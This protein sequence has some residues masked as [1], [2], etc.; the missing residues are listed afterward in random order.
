MIH[1]AFLPLLALFALPTFVAST[2][3]ASPPNFVFILADD[4]GWNALSIPADPGEPASGSPYFQTP[5]LA[6]LAVNGMRF[7]QA[8]SPAPTCSPSRHSIQFGRSPASLRIWGA[9]GIRNWNAIDGESLANVLKKARPEYVCAHFGKWHI[10]RSPEALGYEINDGA[11]GNSAGNSKN[12]KDPKKIFDLSRKSNEFMEKQVQAGRPFYLQVSHYAN[13]LKYQGLRETI[14][15]YETKYAGK[16]TEHH[17]DPLWAAMNENLDTG[18]GMVLDKIDELGIAKNTYVFYTADNGYESKRDFKKTVSERGYYKAFP[19]RSHKYHVSEG[20]IRVPFIVRGPGI[21][22]N[23]HSSFPVVGT[24]VFPTVMDLIESSDKVPSR[25]EGASLMKHLKSGGKE[26]I[27]RKDPFL[28]FKF[29]KP[30]PPHDIAIV[31]GDHKLIKD[32]DTGESFLFNLKK[33]VGESKNIIKENPELGKQ[34]YGNM[35]EYFARFSWDESKIKTR[36]GPSKAKKGPKV[37]PG[38][39]NVTKPRKKRGSSKKKPNV[40]IIFIDDMGY[41]DIGPFGSDHPTPHLDRMA[42]EGMKLTDFYVSSAACTPSR[43]ALLTGCYADRIGMGKSVVFPADKRGLNPKEITIAEILKNAGYAT[44]CFGKWHLGDQPQFMP[45]AQGFDKYE[46]IPYSN[47]MWVKGNPKRKYPPLPWIKGNKPVA[48]IPDQDSQALVTDAITDAAVSFIHANRDNP[49]FCYV[50]HSAVHSP[51]MVTPGRLATAQDDVMQALVSEIDASTGRTLNA[52]RKHGIEKNTLVL[53]TNDNG[54]AGKT[55]SGPLR[56][57]KFGPK[58][59]GHMR[60]ST[61]AWWPGKIP[62]GTVTS[63]IM[64]TIDILPTVAKLAGQPIP[65]DRIIDGRDV[66]DILLGKENAKSPHNYHYYEKDGIRQGK[67][68][69]VRYRV[70]ADRFAELYDLERDLGE[71]NNLSKRYPEKVKALTEVLGAHVKKI[72]AELRPA[73]FVANPK[74]LLADSKGLPSLVEYRNK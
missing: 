56:G 20:G 41:G 46:G 15:K 60:V 43:S 30:R 19:Q 11:N 45:L 9:D 44:G 25:V 73:G 5:H 28:V 58:Y 55:S 67:W 65:Q 64:A 37:A 3:I 21:P 13:H 23:K 54:G 51:H 34:L 50:P 40:V 18:I 14:E 74:P 52:L 48:H 69:L 29:S 31:Q 53:F 59:E 17:K 66:S 68:K 39:T 2:A 38:P 61:L 72:E 16:A 27:D 32:L 47:D 1:N 62:A 42:K 33:D 4:Q 63:E 36:V 24:D 7:S 57:H 26:P 6:K 22:A 49:F 35:T 10:G 8:Y 71:R 12:P 70:K